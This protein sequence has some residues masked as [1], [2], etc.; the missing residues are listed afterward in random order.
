MR[1]FCELDL[2]RG[3]MEM[4][5]K[6]DLLREGE[7]GGGDILN[8]SQ[9][10]FRVRMVRDHYEMTPAEFSAILGIDIETLIEL[11]TGLK[12]LTY[13]LTSILEFCFS[14]NEEWFVS[15]KGDMLDPGTRKELE[16]PLRLFRLF[17]NLSDGGKRKMEGVL[18]S[19]LRNEYQEARNRL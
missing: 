12:P 4:V 18:T 16:S 3:D 5:I 6:S 17:N 15:G 7:I 2:K 8:N 14:V 9:M 1:S 19:F 13:K 10:G 11:E